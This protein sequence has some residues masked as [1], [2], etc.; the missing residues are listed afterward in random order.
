M[1]YNF[2]EAFDRSVFPGKWMG[3]DGVTIPM[4]IAD[5]DFPLMP[6]VQEA[7]K[8]VVDRRDFGYQ[9][10]T[11]DHFEPIIEWIKK[12]TGEDVPR[13]YLL[14]APGVVYAMRCSMYALTEPGDKIVIQTPL[15]TPSI[16]SASMMGRIP[17][18]NW[19]IY[20]DGKY[21]M[22][23]D[24]LEKHF[25]DGAK[26]LMMCAPNNPTGRVWTKEEMDTVAYLADKY[27]VYVVADEIHRDIL[28]DGNKH[29]S[30]SSI[31]LLKD[32]CVS[33]ISTS[34]TFN[35]GGFHIGT[36][37]IPNPEIRQKFK[38]MLYNFGY[39]CGMPTILDKEA[40][41]AAYIH[42]EEWYKEMLSYI[43]GNFDLALSYLDGT[44]IHASKPEATFI[45]WADIT[46]LKL[47]TPDLW[48]TMKNK[49]KVIGDPGSYYDT[50][51]Y[52]DYNGPEHHVRINLA[53]QRVNVEKAF[54]RIRKSLK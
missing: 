54:D 17:L 27:N 23:F 42:G 15:H 3:N 44:P 20:K 33:V 30:P 48:D 35:M 53:T 4:S 37:I 5:M 21:T 7:I 45:L 13:E 19:L 14:D 2:D 43:E 18:K 47:N 28:W 51:D 32:R 46:E 50:K 8:K 36:A 39:A 26:V 11:K 25:K 38:D 49:W 40:Q 34:K 1:R 29:I 10:M 22:D 16:K 9:F 41:T 6:E 31:P 52:A 24:N 12:R